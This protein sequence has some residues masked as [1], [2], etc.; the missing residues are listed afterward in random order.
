MPTSTDGKN[1]TC[2]PQLVRMFRA[3][4][5]PATPPAKPPPQDMNDPIPGPTLRARV[6]DLVQLRFVNEVN[7]NRFD[8]N[9]DIDACTRPARAGPQYPLGRRPAAQLPARV[10]HRQHPL[11]RHP[12]QPELDRRQRLPADPAVAARQPGRPHHDRAGGDGRLRRVLPELRRQD[13]AEAAVRVA[14]DLEGHAAGL[15]QQADRAAD[16][17]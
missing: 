6:G 1:V 11:P 5:S 12:H 15:G 2:S 3:D 13:R 4:P 17:L 9:I 10:E 14:D 7:S 16:G 8:P